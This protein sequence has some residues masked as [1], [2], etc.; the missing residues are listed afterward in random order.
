[1]AEFAPPDGPSTADFADAVP[2]PSESDTVDDASAHDDDDDDG[3]QSPDVDT[4]DIGWGDPDPGPRWDDSPVEE[5]APSF[6]RDD[7]DATAVIF[8]GRNL[9]ATIN[10]QPT[11]Y[12]WFSA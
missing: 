2:D 4:P 5:T 10:T 8:A 3:S 11:G 9:L 7:D 12:H 1:V 6:P